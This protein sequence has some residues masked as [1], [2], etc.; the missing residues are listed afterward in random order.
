[1]A[2]SAEGRRSNKRAGAVSSLTRPGRHLPLVYG[3]VLLLSISLGASVAYAQ[4]FGGDGGPYILVGALVAAGMGLAVLWEWRLGVLMLPATLPYE[5]VLNSG[6]LASGIKALALLTF[7]SLALGFLRERSLFHRFIELWRQPLTLAVFALVLWCL[8]S[9]LWASNQ[10]AALA[11]TGTFLGVFGL[12][13]V[14]GML[15]RRYLVGL[16]AVTT[17][18]AVLSVPAAAYI[19]PQSERMATTGRFSSGI[20]PNDYAGLLVIVFLV[21]HFGFL[22][23]RY[24][25]VSYALAPI[26]FFGIF[27]SG[28]RTGLI[29]LVAA[30]LL[31]AFIPGLTKRVAVRTL[32]MYGL[33]AAALAGVILAIPSVGEAVVE[34]YATLGQYSSEDTWAGRWSI[35]QGAFQVIAT[36]PLLGVGAGNFPYVAINYSVE[37]AKH[38]AEVGM[39]SGVAHNIFLAVTSELGFIGLI[40]FL[41]VL[42]Y[43]FKL[44]WPLSQT[45]ALGTGMFLCLLAYV[46]IGMTMEWGYEKIGYVVLGSLLSLTL[47][48]RYGTRVANEGRMPA[49]KGAANTS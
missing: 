30:P 10:E 34:R 8:A 20:H 23:E 40:L 47:Q 7:F 37:V 3:G 44:A 24:R 42:F 13:V 22:R 18:S 49:D 25:I 21:A 17:L 14:V 2:I 5:G 41:G 6:P 45:S 31:A 38:A 39:G 32:L 15:E 46:I 27:A 35:W 28:S 48:E 12:M 43:G 4:R 9:I 26:L 1:M 29:A 16:W 36:N 19:L 33:T 11:R